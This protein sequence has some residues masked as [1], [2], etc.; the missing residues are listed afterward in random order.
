MLWWVQNKSGEFILKSPT[1]EHYEF[2]KVYS[3]LQY[4]NQ[5]FESV[6]ERKHNTK[7]KKIMLV[8]AFR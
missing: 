1:I 8:Y 6:S 3:I 5:C 7:K 2:Q 4:V